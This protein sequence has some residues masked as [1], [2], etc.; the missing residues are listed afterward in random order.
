MHSVFYSL[1]TENN[2]I[3]YIMSLM[4]LLHSI[5]QLCVSSTKAVRQSVKE[6]AVYLRKYINCL[7]TKEILIAVVIG[8]ITEKENLNLFINNFSYGRNGD[9]E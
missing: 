5:A 3:F 7:N 4:K 6:F 8:I 2:T 1:V 9:I